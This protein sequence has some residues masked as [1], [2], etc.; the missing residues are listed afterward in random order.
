MKY[1]LDKIK[2]IIN[3]LTQK[4]I[5]IAI[6][7]SCTGGY[8]SHMFTNISGASKV[9]ERGVVSYSNEAKI[10]VLNVKSETINKYGAASAQV[11][12]QMAEN[13]RNLS[14]VDIGVGITGIAGPTGG[15]EE[16]P[17]GLVYIGFSTQMDTLIKK[18]IFKTDRI[19]FKK[20]VLDEIILLLNDYLKELKK[21]VNKKL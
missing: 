17:I 3:D 21:S 14:K 10:E 15:T 4:K 2:K 16:K 12:R 7:E 8:I 6:A 13:I 18:F 1:K 5:Q 11:A 19:S 9:F 20:K